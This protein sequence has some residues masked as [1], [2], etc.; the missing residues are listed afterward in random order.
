MVTAWNVEK[1]M[2]DIHL[3]GRVGDPGDN[4]LFRGQAVILIVS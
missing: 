4:P 3:I 2:S 1:K